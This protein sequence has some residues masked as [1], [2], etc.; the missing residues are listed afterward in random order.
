VQQSKEAGF[1]GHL[2]KPVDYAELTAL[3]GMRSEPRTGPGAQD[4]QQRPAPDPTRPA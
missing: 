3:L 2:V 1:D 4:G